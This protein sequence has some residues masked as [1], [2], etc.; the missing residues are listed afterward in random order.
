MR[1]GPAGVEEE[2]AFLLR[3]AWP[4]NLEDQPWQTLLEKNKDEILERLS[5]KAK[6]KVQRLHKKTIKGL[7]SQRAIPW[8]K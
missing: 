7:K 6:F 2:W 4:Q 8:Q 3:L 1:L 5:P